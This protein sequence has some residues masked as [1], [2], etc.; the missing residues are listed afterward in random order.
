M[1]CFC[2]VFCF[3][4]GERSWGR[5]AAAQDRPLVY[6]HVLHG[7]SAQLGRFP[8]CSSGQYSEKSTAPGQ[9]WEF[10][11]ASPAWFL[12]AGYGYGLPISRLYARYFQGDLK[13]YSLEG[14][15][16][17]A[18]IYIRVTSLMLT[19]ASLSG[20]KGEFLPRF[21]FFFLSIFRHFPQSRLRD[22]PSTTNRPG[23]II[24]RYTRPMTG[25]SPARSPKT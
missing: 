15:G 9:H 5:R 24:R 1:T 12:Q 4:A 22:S 10:P 14:Y 18:V 3:F 21:H 8:R 13:L 7:S 11:Q 19:G 16:T 17:D 20:V 25:A 23:N 6:L 2:F